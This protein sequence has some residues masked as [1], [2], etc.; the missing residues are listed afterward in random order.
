MKRGELTTTQIIGIVLAIIGFVAILFFLFMNL[1]LAGFSEES[2]CKASVL[3]RAVAPNVAQGLVPLKCN[4]KKICITNGTGNCASQFRGEEG[5]TIIKLKG[6][7]NNA[8][9]VRAMRNTIERISAE[10]MYSCWSMM[11]EGKLD[12]FGKFST[13]LGIKSVV[14][15][16][17]ICSRIAIDEGVK[18]DILYD[19][20][21]GAGINI[22]EY[23]RKNNV[24]GKSVT[25]LQAFT[26]KSVSSY[27]YANND[28]Y[29][30][31]KELNK[32]ESVSSSMDKNDKEDVKAYE[33]GLKTIQVS[34]SGKDLSNR[35]MAV[36]FMQVK[37]VKTA[38]VLKNM[39]VVGGT[40]VAGA[41]MTPVVNKVAG[42]V[43]KKVLFNPYGIAATV[44]TGT[45]IGGYGAYNAYQGQLTAAG[46]CGAFSSSDDRASEGCSL[47]QGVNYNLNDI[48]ALCKSIQGRP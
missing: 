43:A 41:F 1:D 14:P 33:K 18:R 38:D 16:C 36:V 13:D 12:I 2:A 39:L 15:S 24:P 31:L 26:D 23:M 5:V 8:K 34:E 25:F 11:G 21:A 40:V 9:D 7:M 4:T 30:N 20:S 17:V 45:A 27:S 28:A 29:E 10:E 35:Q 32:L 44:I 3:T 6:K 42:N 22:N 48:N 19:H 46:Y 47:V 37:S